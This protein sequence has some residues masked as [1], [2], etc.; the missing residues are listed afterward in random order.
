MAL[1][2]TATLLAG[3]DPRPVQIDVTGLTIGRAY[4]VT[5][6]T[7]SGWS[8]TVQGGSG[9]SSATQIVFVDIATPLN[10]ALTYTAQELSDD[11]SVLA[12]ASTVGTVTVAYDHDALISSL[13]GSVIAPIEWMDNEDPREQE[14]RQALF[15]P[16]GSTRPIVHYDLSGDESGT[17][18]AET[19]GTGTTALRSLIRAGAPVL[20]RTALG[21]RD[22]DPVEVLVITRAPRKLVGATGTLRQWELAYTLGVDGETVPLVVAML[23]HVNDVYATKYLSDFNTDFAGQTLAQVNIRDWV[24]DSA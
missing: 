15:R 6:S 21:I 11:G 12:S 14:I 5:A 2:I 19:S 1:A 18:V 9:T 13:D 16:A 4:L 24:G 17:I 7:S 8:R 10:A 22:V 23:S 3:A 20:I